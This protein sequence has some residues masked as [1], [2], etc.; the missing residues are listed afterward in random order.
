MEDRL[1]RYKEFMPGNCHFSAL[2]IA[3][4]VKGV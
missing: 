1:S 4:Q 2:M 3:S